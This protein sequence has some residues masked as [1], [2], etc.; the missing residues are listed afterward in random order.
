MHIHHTIVRALC[1][2]IFL[3]LA[4]ASGAEAQAWLTFDLP[5]DRGSLSQMPISINGSNPIAST[6]STNSGALLG[7][8][9]TSDGTV[10]TFTALG[11]G[12]YTTVYGLNAGGDVAGAVIDSSG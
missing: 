12:S 2:G 8:V 3:G 6:Y 5:D 9:R 10:T 1:G 4:A 11:D 7:Y